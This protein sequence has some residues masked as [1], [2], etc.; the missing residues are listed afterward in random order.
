MIHNA[1]FWKSSVYE[2]NPAR[3]ILG[4]LGLAATAFGALLAIRANPAGGATIAAAGVLAVVE[5][6]GDLACAWD[7]FLHRIS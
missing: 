3:V 2:P 5:C 1:E 7:R 6:R 4:L